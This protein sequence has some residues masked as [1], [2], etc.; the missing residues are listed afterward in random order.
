M[1]LS[2]NQM[3]YLDDIIYVDQVLQGDTTAF[4]RLVDKHK[5][6]VF[7]IAFKV[8]RQRE[9]AE[10]VAQDVFVKAY[11]KLSTFKRASKFSTWLYRIAYNESIS[12]V[13]KF[14]P[15]TVEVNEETFAGIP[16]E[17]IRNE[18]LGLDEAEQKS[19][20]ERVF[21]SLNEMESALVSLFYL[22]DTPV[23]EISEITGLSESNVKDIKRIPFNSRN[24]SGIISGSI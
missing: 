14:H 7:T 8:T 16:D 22:Q 10:E 6:L 24:D 4:A 9:E 13:R 20:F 15:D 3:E 23:D 17:Q 18:V 1:T 19:L 2:N 12:R 11:Q 21:R 5:D